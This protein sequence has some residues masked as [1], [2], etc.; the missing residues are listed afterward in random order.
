MHVC[1]Y[2]CVSNKASFVCSVKDPDRADRMKRLLQQKTRKLSNTRFL[3]LGMSKVHTHTC[4]PDD[5]AFAQ[6]PPLSQI[7]PKPFRHPILSD[8]AS[9]LEELVSH[10]QI[11]CTHVTHSKRVPIPTMS[12]RVKVT[13]FCIAWIYASRTLTSACMHSA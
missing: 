9:P 1:M 8:A 10:K 7:N 5:C 2:V 12:E 3:D 6:P 11:V 4:T 13:K